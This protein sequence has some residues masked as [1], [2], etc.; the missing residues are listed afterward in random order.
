MMLWTIYPPEVVFR[1][2]ETPPRQEE[3]AVGGRIFLVS[4]TEGGQ[5]QIER[6]ISTDPA[7]YLNP[8]WQ[9]GQ[10]LMMPGKNR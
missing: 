5:H 8:L 2:E 10:I 7:D 9:P 3:V 1:T 4:R 6:L